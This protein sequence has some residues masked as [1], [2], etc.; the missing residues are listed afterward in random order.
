[1]Q[2][3]THFLR[4]SSLKCNEQTKQFLPWLWTSSE[5]N[6][7]TEK[8]KHFLCCGRFHSLLVAFR[9]TKWTKST[10][11]QDFS[12]EA[13][14]KQNIKARLASLSCNLSQA[15]TV[16]SS[17]FAFS[18]FHS[19]FAWSFTGNLLHFK[20]SEGRGHTG[21]WQFLFYL[22]VNKLPFIDYFWSMFKKLLQVFFMRTF[23]RCCNWSIIDSSDV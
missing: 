23:F 2:S 22:T 17:I 8:K 6:G 7:Q 11:K 14:S 18:V 5:V 9:N 4:S 12:G 21:I 16:W 10:I 19:H 3:L 13:L 1:M 15:P 20:I